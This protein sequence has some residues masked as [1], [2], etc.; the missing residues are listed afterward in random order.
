[1]GT[2]E[3]GNMKHKCHPSPTHQGDGKFSTPFVRTITLLKTSSQSVT[4][5]LLTVSGHGMSKSSAEINFHP[6][7]EGL[8][9]CRC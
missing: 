1:M 2:V 8:K 3:V 9:M 6:G 4:R 5:D 7:K